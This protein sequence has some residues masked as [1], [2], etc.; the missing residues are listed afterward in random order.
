MTQWGNMEKTLFRKEVTADRR[1]RDEKEQDWPGLLGWALG[2]VC[3]A[4]AFVQGF[5][6][7]RDAEVT[8]VSFGGMFPDPPGLGGVPDSLFGIPVEKTAGG[9]S[10][11]TSKLTA[12]AEFRARFEPASGSDVLRLLGALAFARERDGGAV[13]GGSLCARLPEGADPLE[14]GFRSLYDPGKR[15]P[16]APEPGPRWSRFE[17]K[18]PRLG[19]LPEIDRGTEFLTACGL[20]KFAPKAME[21]L[22]WATDSGDGQL[23]VWRGVDPRTFR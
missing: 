21:A 5:P 14:L 4:L 9:T 7:L 23:A 13:V 19:I 6:A 1:S 17:G 8:L 3:S 2:E 10:D 12:A 11:G 16:S 20:K 15:D 18:T 22:D